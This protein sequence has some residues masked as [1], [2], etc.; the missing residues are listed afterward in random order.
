MNGV[1]PI[2]ST[3]DDSSYDGDEDVGQRTQQERKPWDVFRDPPIRESSGSVS[4]KRAL[5]TLTKLVK[6]LAIIF[7][8]VVVLGSAV[9][10]KG[11]V[12]FM[13]SQLRKGKQTVYCNKGLGGEKQFAAELPEE[14]RVAWMWCILIAYAV[15]ELGTFIRASRMCFF[16]TVAKPSLPEF[17][18]AFF[19]ETFHT[20]GMA[21]L[22]F[23][24]LPNLDVLKGVMLTNCLCFIPGV[25]AIASRN[26]NEPGRPIKLVADVAAT[27]IQ[28]TGFVVWPMLEGSEKLQLW[29]IPV[30]TIFISCGWWEN[31]IS[32]TENAPLGFVKPLHQIMKRLSATRY[33]N[34][35][36][37]SCWKILC[38]F[39]SILVILALQNE[40]VNNFFSLLPTAFGPH[41][42]T[43]IEVISSDAGTSVLDE[44]LTTPEK[45]EM[46][47]YYYA[48]V[49]V[50]IIQICAA[51]ICY[52]FGKFACKIM[53]QPIAFAFPVNV[54]VPLSI[55]LLI[56]MCGL[57][58]TDPCTYQNIIPD[59]LFFDAPSSYTVGDF[60]GT[61]HAWIWLLWLFSQTWITIHL[62]SPQCKRLSPTD[63]LFVTPMYNSLLIDQSLAL[64]RRRDD[65]NMEVIEPDIFADDELDDA[66]ITEKEMLGPSDEVTRIYACATMW[67]ETRDEMLEMLKSVFRMDIDQSARRLARKYFGIDDPDYYEFETHILFDDAFETTDGDRVV[68]SYVKLLVSVIDEAA[69]LVHGTTIRLR[70]PVK[71]PTPYGGRLVWT[72]PGKTKIYCHLKDGDKIRTRKRWSQVMYMY[73]LLGHRLMEKPIS[74]HQK[75]AIARNTYLLAM[76]G[77]IDFQPE[78]VL[79]LVDLM[80]KDPNLGAACGRIHPIGSG[81]MQWY[82][83]F[84]YAI[85]HWLQKATEHIIGCVLCSPGAFSLFRAKALMDD[86]VMNKYAFRSCEARHYVQFDQGEDRWLCTLLLQRGYRVEYAAAS[87]SYTHCPEGFNEFFNQRRRWIPSTTANILDLL[88]DSKRTIKA[89]DNISLPYIM[90][91]ILLMGGT[92]LGPGTIFL[93]LTGACV[94]AFRIDNWTSFLYNVTPILLFMLV[95]YT[96]KS[97][98]QLTVAMIIT[99]G[100]SLVMM[101]VLV[102]L[103][104]Q[105]QEDGILAPS[106]LFLVL[107]AA[108]FLIAAIFHPKEMYCLPPIVVY[109]ITIPSMYL[110]LIIYS[111]FNLNNISW[112][113]RES[114]KA[115]T[116]QEQA[117]AIETKKKDKKKGMFSFLTKFTDKTKSNKGSIEFSLANLF[118]CMCCTYPKP[119]EETERLLM[120]SGSLEAI[121]KRLETLERILD[122]SSHLNGRLRVRQNMR[123]N[124]LM[125][126]P[127]LP[128]FDQESKKNS[129]DDNESVTSEPKED[130]IDDVNPFWIED[131]K[132]KKGEIDYL[133][134]T[135][136]VFWT[137][138]IAAY[139][140]PLFEDREENKEEK[141]RITKDLKALRDTSVFAFFMI[142]ALFVLV[143]FLLQ[144]NKETI[145][146]QWPLGAKANITFVEDN[147]E[148]KVTKEYLELEPIGLVFALFFGIVL[149]IQFFAMMFHRLG[150]LSHILAS[151]NVNLFS[152]GKDNDQEDE[153]ALRKE[154]IAVVSHMQQ[155][156]PE[157]D[158]EQ[159]KRKPSQRKLTCLI[160]SPQ[161]PKS[162][163]LANNFKVSIQQFMN[164]GERGIDHFS[165]R[166]SLRK[167]TASHLM[168]MHRRT[169]IERRNSKA[170]AANN[171]MSTTYPHLTSPAHT[172]ITNDGHVNAG[173]DGFSEDIG[174]NRRPSQK[175]KS[176]VTFADT[177][178]KYS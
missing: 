11:T 146:I 66:H 60:L 53:I 17:L 118:K 3:E 139:L 20:I 147:N 56:V 2:E 128:E 70:P 143:V 4:D 7:T 140:Y 57:K 72:L 25:L 85:G 36:F 44:A 99:V 82:Q 133:S 154:I 130:R 22:F 62:W 102:G 74:V 54:T 15:P 80:K 45:F 61:Q 6:V 105:I 92:V 112:G 178:V 126:H 136:K 94:T 124:P 109:Y 26:M 29:L 16:K 93:M 163:N 49:F 160:S 107:C 108:E 50:L 171:K 170:L 135:E 14:E 120:I 131:R 47:A 106:S 165:H 75:E 116:Q 52:I 79:L 119:S 142:N 58:N 84:E 32:A 71:Y 115:Q 156:P 42:I 68:N 40:N 95:C 111:V 1:N 177:D 21:L 13:T 174:I 24:I 89:N 35:L 158:E 33:Y 88:M 159:D 76:D 110:L 96:C 9:L 134:K 144:Q 10:V 167:R 46:D 34:Y 27:A 157:A 63:R 121:G 5:V 81:P 78:A 166:Y 86:S 132:L 149:I 175:R 123:E 101:A 48:S 173:F 137:D 103:I 141:A 23:V 100:Y 19:M 155:M 117:V 39:V 8:T 55:S 150:T 97:D 129:D 37:I 153:E 28:A 43:V 67:H 38:F 162:V 125:P 127:E 164:D 73:Y 122:P 104:L 138:L 152:C 148:A 176:I 91:Q 98:I 18:I 87:D 77:D 168:N 151:T 51:Y 83:V 114:P 64:N 65:T 169:T 31:Y 41:K 172:E 145:Y 113:T 161:A 90:Y 30:T 59:Y 69:T 12:L